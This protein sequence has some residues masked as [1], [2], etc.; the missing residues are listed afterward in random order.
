MSHGEGAMGFE[1]QQAEGTLPL[2]ATGLPPVLSDANY[3]IP[4]HIRI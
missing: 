1:V 3:R 4:N 2:S